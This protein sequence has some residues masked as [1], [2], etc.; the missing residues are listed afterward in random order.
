MLIK[1][2]NQVL[3]L[4]DRKNSGLPIT[5]FDFTTSLG[6]TDISGGIPRE[7]DIEASTR[8]GNRI[9]WM[10]SQSNNDDGSSRVN[11]DRIFATDISG[12]GA[13]TTLSYVGR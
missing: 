2:E 13:S 12:T 1:D 6:L 10:G 8:I 5:G 4:Y 9:Y 7:V 11:R 3:R